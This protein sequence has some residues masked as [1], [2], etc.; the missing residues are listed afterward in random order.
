MEQPRGVPLLVTLFAVLMAAQGTRLLT[1]PAAPAATVATVEEARALLAAAAQGLGEPPKKSS[2]EPVQAGWVEPLRLYREL[3]GLPAA[4]P[5]GTQSDLGAVAAEARRSKLHLE[6]IVALVPDPVDSNLAANFD[7]AVEA[8]QTAGADSGYLLDRLWLPWTGDAAKANLFR[9]APGILLFRGPAGA[10]GPRLLAVYLVGETPK[11]GIHTRAMAAALELATR[12]PGAAAPEAFPEGAPRQLPAAGATLAAQRLVAPGTPSA[13]PIVRILGPSFSG[14]APSLRRSLLAWRARGAGSAPTGTQEKAGAGTSAETSAAETS[15]RDQTGA[16]PDKAATETSAAATSATETSA[17]NQSAATAPAPPAEAFRIVTGS[18]TAQGLEQDFAL[19]PG[20]TFERTV[21]PDDEL[22]DH[23]FRFL[24]DQLGWEPGNIALLAE[25]DTAYGQQEDAL[26][27]LV[28][29]FPSG[30]SSLRSAWEKDEAAGREAQGKGAPLSVP[31]NALG[32]SLTDQSRPVDLAPQF[33]TLSTASHDLALS[34]LLASIWRGGVRYVGILSTDVR[35]KLYLAERI[36]RFAPD[37]VVFTLDNN[38]LYAHPQ[39][40]AALD[41]T[42]VLSS[43]PLYTEYEG[44]QEIFDPLPPGTPRVRY[45]RQFTSEFQQGIFLA[46]KKLL[47][48]EVVRPRGW[49]AA[50]GN[51]TLWPLASLPAPAPS[52]GFEALGGRGDLQVLL[53]AAVLCLL[54]L[55]LRAVY[56]QREM[57]EGTG[58]PDLTARRLLAFGCA[59]LAVLGASIALVGTLPLWGAGN[60]WSLRSGNGADRFFEALYLTALAAA[61]VFLVWN[62]ARATVPPVLP[63][64]SRAGETA[65]GRGRRVLAA[66]AVAGVL[67]LPALAVLMRLWWM[68]G[69][70][71][72]FYLRARKLTSGL[73]PVLPLLLLGGSLFCWVLM[74]LKRRRLIARQAIEWPL[75]WRLEP[76]L[77]GVE[78]IAQ[79]VFRLIRRTFPSPLEHGRRG[80]Q[81]RWFWTALGVVLLPPAVML[82]RTVQPIAESRQYGRLFLVLALLAFCLAAVSFF[83]F[84][85]LWL[86]LDR[87]LQRLDHTRLSRAF[88]K[89]SDEV[90]WSPMRAFGWHPQTYKML[91]LSA[92]RLRPLVIPPVR[93]ELRNNLD[94]LFLADQAGDLGEGT[95]ARGELGR[96]FDDA[97]REL[98]RESGRSEVEEFLAVRT[99]AFLRPVIAHMRNCLSAALLTTLLLL[100]AVRSYA[101]E[102]EWFISVGIWAAITIGVAITLWVFVQMDRNASL[103]AIGGTPQGKVTFDRHFFT[104]VMTYGAIPLAGIAVTQFP[105]IGRFVSG[106]LNPVLQVAGGG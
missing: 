53:I 3:L 14:S 69:G 11:Q 49:I 93:E 37:M 44:W 72:L 56:P 32:L 60:G 42:L 64:T 98:A 9:D 52:V 30:L 2:E 18:A 105:Q 50:V 99:V 35:D 61:Y 39:H 102:P 68:P 38:L 31:R 89:I 15:A 17:T 54:A 45:R 7:Q 29:R 74:E 76:P 28:V 65:R 23:T 16:A 67:L 27:L 86:D 40:S 88:R 75:R 33:S 19:L 81:G 25:S 20:V 24:I 83:Q 71:E 94:A 84:F 97:S 47:G 103:S 12:L 77:E 104:N 85:A 100:F 70:A 21:M 34:N 1:G 22:Q 63:G 87:L 101:F 5:P 57:L 55:W 96:L 48:H 4:K 41:G 62:A 80:I 92:E 6:S 73:S 10:S 58:E 79:P 36:R 59:V 26:P 106:W 91:V 95:R 8:I 43:F 51:G 46:G 13:Q 78:A 66:W 90:A 82:L